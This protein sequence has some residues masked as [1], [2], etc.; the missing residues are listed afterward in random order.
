MTSAYFEAHK[1]L[2]WYFHSCALPNTSSLFDSFLSTTSSPGEPTHQSSPVPPTRPKNSVW[3]LKFQVIN[4]DSILPKKDELDSILHNENLDFVFGCETH[5]YSTISSSEFLPPDYT[6]IRLDR[7][8]LG[9]GVIVIHKSNL[10]VSVV[11]N[12]KDA[13]LKVKVQ[14]EG[15]KNGNL[16]RS[17]SSTS[18]WWILHI[19]TV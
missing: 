16:Q 8:R 12:P 17:I 9:G 13:E 7:D 5:L 14:C 10:S 6:A 19:K 3:R 15:K 4:F 1:N 2:S 18:Q 11:H